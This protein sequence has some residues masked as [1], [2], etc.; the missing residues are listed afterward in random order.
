[1]K[2][3]CIMSLP[4]VEEDM[5]KLP[6]QFES[7]SAGA[8]LALLFLGASLWFKGGQTQHFGSQQFSNL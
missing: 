5:G 8:G 7:S 1:M 6:L 2:Q 4:P 3:I